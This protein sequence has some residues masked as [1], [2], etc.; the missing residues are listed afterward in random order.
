M[1]FSAF[2]QKQIAP[3]RQEINIFAKEDTHETIEPSK[4]IP[5]DRHKPSSTRT[6]TVLG[7]ES[8]LE[9]E[10]MAEY[11]KKIG[12]QLE[13]IEGLFKRSEST[14]STPYGK[15]ITN[16]NNE[17]DW[18]RQ[19]VALV[20]SMGKI[21]NK[22]DNENMNV[23]Q[24]MFQ[25]NDGNSAFLLNHYERLAYT[26]A[27]IQSL[28]KHMKV[29]NGNYHIMLLVIVLPN[30]PD[31]APEELYSTSGVVCKYFDWKDVQEYMSTVISRYGLITERETDVSKASYQT[32]MNGL[33]VPTS[34]DM[35]P[36]EQFD[37]NLEFG[38]S[39]DKALS[40]DMENG[41]IAEQ[42]R[43]TQERY[44]NTHKDRAKLNISDKPGRVGT[45]RSLQQRVQEVLVPADDDIP[46]RVQG[47]QLRFNERIQPP[48]QKRPEFQIFD[49]DSTYVDGENIPQN[50]PS[51]RITTIP[52]VHQT[53]NAPRRGR[54]VTNNPKKAIYN[55]EREQDPSRTPRRR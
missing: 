30:S 28:E 53:T 39:P 2:K 49:D 27:K 33:A 8:S 1:S 23:I 37:M 21:F 52:I 13:I 45:G 55:M 17:N 22:I 38:L 16:L 31:S 25:S 42:H 51:T 48:S 15:P 43:I 5:P 40:L 18:Y 26:D 32:G 46:D 9:N 47:V 24:G 3:R 19:N 20:F 34:R 35:K 14:L 6:S 29:A 36:G 11:Q 50:D 12:T 7:W 10:R 4:I 54:L 44:R 41:F